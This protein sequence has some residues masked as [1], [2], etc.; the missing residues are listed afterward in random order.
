MLISCN[1]LPGYKLKANDGD[2]GNV[3]D[4]LFDDKHKIIRY[5]V[6]DCGSWLQKNEVLLSPIAFEEPD[7]E[8]FT[9]STILS[10]NSI[11]N[12]PSVETRP[13]VSKQ[14][15]NSLAAYYDWP[16]FW[17]TAP[18]EHLQGYED[19]NADLKGEDEGQ[20]QSLQE[21][22]G[23]AIQCDEGNLGHVE[24]LIVDTETWTLRYL[25][26]DTG[27]WLPGKKVIISID[28]LTDI[29]WKEQKACLNLSKMD[30]RNAPVYDPGTPINR[31][32][33]SEVYDYYGR[34]SY[35]SEAGTLSL[36][37]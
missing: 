16:I 7:H 8:N 3:T 10:K 25:T 20:L 32:F 14:A 9:I 31:E 19:S 1:I 24:E 6:I 26:I 4:L 12:S 17:K 2:F 13:P 35:W 29:S 37:E 36:Y 22:K 34:P 33:E 18:Y 15:Q 27:N 21:I 5:F 11:E 23:Y 30:V 28:W